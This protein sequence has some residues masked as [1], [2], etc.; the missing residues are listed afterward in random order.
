[1]TKGTT[2]WLKVISININTR[3]LCSSDVLCTTQH[4]SWIVFG[5]NDYTQMPSGNDQGAK[6]CTRASK[7]ALCGN[8]T[9]HHI[10]LLIM[11]IGSERV[12]WVADFV[13]S[14]LTSKKTNKN[15]FFCKLSVFVD[16][17]ASMEGHTGHVGTGCRCLSCWESDCLLLPTQ[18]VYLTP[19]MVEGALAN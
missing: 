4:K 7:T 14:R 11:M 6:V 5:R 2:Q 12:W 15:V 10:T 19:G 17:H 9:A 1:M 18:W 16:C 8:I 13:F 3:T